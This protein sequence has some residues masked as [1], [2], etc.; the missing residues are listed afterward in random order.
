M[1]KN[2]EKENLS[3]SI[4]QQLELQ[5][6]MSPSKIVLTVEILEKESIDGEEVST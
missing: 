1:L 4:L 6:S 3:S 2:F 5:S